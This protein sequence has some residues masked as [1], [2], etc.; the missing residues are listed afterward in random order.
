MDSLLM[1]VSTESVSTYFGGGRDC[2]CV[3]QIHCPYIF[4]HKSVM[5]F[6]MFFYNTNYWTIHSINGLFTIRN[7]WESSLEREEKREWDRWGGKPVL[8]V[9][10]VS[11][12]SSADYSEPEI[13]R[14]LSQICRKPQRGTDELNRRGGVKLTVGIVSQWDLR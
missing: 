5:I 14:A 2:E 8:L 3:H 7:R 4:I 1:R 9:D 11:K 6:I 13:D 10:L 12:P